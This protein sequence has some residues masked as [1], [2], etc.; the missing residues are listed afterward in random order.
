MIFF[1]F[2]SLNLSPQWKF[3]GDCSDVCVLSKLRLTI[4]LQ[5]YLFFVYFR[6]ISK[7]S[8]TSV[9]SLKSFFYM[10]QGL[11]IKWRSKLY[12]IVALK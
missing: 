2:S 11:K 7:V 6:L 9:S 3:F 4:M 5:S 1:I 12:E 8:E 10:F